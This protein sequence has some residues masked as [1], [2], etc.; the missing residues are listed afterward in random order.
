MTHR[1]QTGWGNAERATRRQQKHELL[2]TFMANARNSGKPLPA[3]SKPALL[4]A[5][6]SFFL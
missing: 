2:L 5:L 1:Q 4:K 3:K 6:F